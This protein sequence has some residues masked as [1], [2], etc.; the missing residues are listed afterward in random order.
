VSEK[1][2]NNV[3]ET[4]VAGTVAKLLSKAPSPYERFLQGTYEDHE[5]INSQTDVARLVPVI[6]P[7]GAKQPSRYLAT[8]TD[9]QH[10]VRHDDGSVDVSDEVVHAEILFPPDY[11][12][13]S[14]PNLA[15]R[16][17]RIKSA[18]FHP[19]VA[20]LPAAAAGTAPT[21]AGWR[22]QRLSLAAGGIVCLGHGFRPGTRLRG[23]IFQLHRIISGKDYATES[24]L[25]CEASSYFL[26]HLERVRALESPPL[27]R[28]RISRR[29]DGT[30]DG[31]AG[32]ARP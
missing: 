20:S 23:L 6:E 1:T 16:V 26:A 31:G 24:P 2:H 7:G 9:L 32:E 14:D 19:N 29:V 17:V 22:P 25:D 8:F 5:R 21:I 3:S 10:F 4:G 18:V 11:L 27:W 12:R 28:T 15:F 13:S 30:E